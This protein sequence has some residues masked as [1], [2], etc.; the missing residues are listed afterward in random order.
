MKWDPKW[1][2]KAKSIGKRYRWPI[3]ILLLGIGLVLRPGGKQSA[4][5]APT[6]A[7][8]EEAAFSEEDYCRQ[9]ERRLAEILSRVEGAGEVRVMLTLRSGPAVRYQTDLSSET[10][11]DG[12]ETRTSVEKKTVILSSGGSYNEA[13][14]INTE[15]PAFRGALIVSGGADDAGVRYQLISAV[16]SLLG[17]GADQITVVKMK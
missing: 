12:G 1:T 16:S 4:Q 6:P 13:A 11:T 9:T 2:E 3:L 7:E 8:T 14:V 5:T 17:L 15:Y 10:R